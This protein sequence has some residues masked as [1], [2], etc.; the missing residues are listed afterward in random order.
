MAHEKVAKFPFKV[1]SLLC[2]LLRKKKQRIRHQKNVKTKDKNNEEKGTQ[3]S[4]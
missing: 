3:T 2:R 4:D 1:E